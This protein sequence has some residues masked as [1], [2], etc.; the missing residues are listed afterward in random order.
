[1]RARKSP[2]PEVLQREAEVVKLRR[3]GLTWDM[4]ADRV[5][6][7]SPSAAHAAYQRAS[8]RIV[9]DDIEAIR[10]IETERLDIMQSAVWGQV[11]NGSIPAVMAVVRIQERRAR[12]LGLDQP[13]KQQIEVTSYDGNSIDREV[14]RLVELLD[15]S[16][17]GALDTSAGQSEPDTNRD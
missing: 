16:S 15:S 12:L 13:F 6:Y 8:K 4:I 2:K 14:A 11:L 5:G 9:Q 10:K 7:A 17:Q 3:G 1:M